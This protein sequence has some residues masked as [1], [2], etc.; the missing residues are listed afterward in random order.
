MRLDAQSILAL[1]ASPFGRSLYLV[2]SINL[3]RAA[4]RDAHIAVA[5]SAG[6]CELLTS[7]RLADKAVS[8]G[9]IKPSQKGLAGSVLRLL[10]LSRSVGGDE[11]DLVLDFSPRVATL[12]FGL[13]RRAKILT[14]VASRR[15]SDSNASI[16][17]KA[18]RDGRAA[19]ESI[20]GQLDLSTDISTW[21]Q[22]PAA[23]ESVRFEELLARSGSRGGEPLLLLYTAE[24]GWSRS[25]PINKY[26]ELA[27]RLHSSYGVRVIAADVPYSSDFTGRIG[28]LLPKEAVKL[29]APRAAELVAAVAR[30]SLVVT[31]DSG[32]AEM[33][34]GLGTPVI[35]VGAAQGSGR[36]HD[37]SSR[38]IEAVYQDACHLLQTSRTGGLFRGQGGN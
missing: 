23:F 27:I 34:G 17:S 31:D 10:K 19:Y 4:H 9:P 38:G 12:L 13:T 11:V 33:A 22:V 1:D 35:D 24:P 36:A 15:K 25:W 2:P 3:I 26:A 6:I 20:L 28:V 14:P 5:A 16:R 37:S 30:S 29:R 8:L 32:I 18:R 21:S 7:L